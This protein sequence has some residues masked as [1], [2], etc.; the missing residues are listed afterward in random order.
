[1]KRFFSIIILLFCFC[2]CGSKKNSNNSDSLLEPSISMGETLV[3]R[4][5]TYYNDHTMIKEFD[6]DGTGRNIADTGVTLEFSYVILNDHQIQ[7]TMVTIENVKKTS[8]Y[9]FEL[10]DN[11]LIYDGMEFTRK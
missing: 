4:W 8:I 7:Q 10:S 5:E 11:T 1:M 9:E 2:S 3:G 6:S